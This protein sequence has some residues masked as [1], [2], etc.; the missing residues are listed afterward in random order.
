MDRSQV[1]GVSVVK[2]EVSLI[3]VL[4]L[5]LITAL[6][7]YQISTPQRLP[8][9]NEPTVNL[10]ALGLALLVAFIVAFAV[11]WM[12]SADRTWVLRAAAGLG[13]LG[14]IIGVIV[15]STKG[16]TVYA[17]ER[18]TWVGLAL[19]TYSFGSGAAALFKRG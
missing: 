13:I 9:D 12:L 14:V 4:V 2:P 16:M 6:V 7:F 19:L 15:V 5:A 1:Q 10:N 18:F 8:L 17:T 11:I 3:I